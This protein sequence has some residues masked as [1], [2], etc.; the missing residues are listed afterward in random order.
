MCGMGFLEDI[1]FLTSFAHIFRWRVQWGMAAI[2]RTS[3]S[4]IRSCYGGLKC[5][6][7]KALKLLPIFKANGAGFSIVRCFGAEEGLKNSVDKILQY[8]YD[9]MRFFFF[10]TR[11]QV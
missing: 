7:G 5:K 9:F 1:R 6:N 4:R 10:L 2:G 3:F 11:F 8:A